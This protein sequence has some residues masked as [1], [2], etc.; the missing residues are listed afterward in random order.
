MNVTLSSSW[1][2]LSGYAY[3]LKLPALLGRIFVTNATQTQSKESISNLFDKPPE[4]LNAFDRCDSPAQLGSLFC[5]LVLEILKQNRIPVGS[6]FYFVEVPEQASA[7][8]VAYD[9][10]LPSYNSRASKVALEGVLKLLNQLSRDSTDLSLAIE[11]KAVLDKQLRDYAPQGVNLFNIF[12]AAQRLNIP[13]EIATGNMVRLGFG[14]HRR[15]LNSTITDRTPSLGVSLAR[16]K[17]LTAEVLR[18][19]GLPGSINQ[20]ANSAEQAVSLAKSIGFPVVVKPADL[21]QGVGV[22]ADLRTEDAVRAAFRLSSEHSKRVLIE[23][24]CEGFTHRLTVS[25][26]E[27]IRVVK[28]IA[29]GVIGDGT[30]T[31][32]ELISRLSTDQ[33]VQQKRTA[34]RHGKGQLVTIDEETLGLLAQMKRTLSDIPAKGEYIRLRRRDNINA[35]GRN[36]EVLLADVHPDNLALAIRAARLLG[37]DIAGIDFISPDIS[38]SWLEIPS[39]ICEVNA[40]PQLGG[41]SRPEVY[42]TLIKKIVGNCTVIPIE[43]ILCSK[44]PAARSY[45]RKQLEDARPLGT[46]ISEHAGLFTEGRRCSA[47]FK[48]DFEAA[49]ALANSPEV[50]QGAVIMD[51]QEIVQMGSPLDRWDKVS[52]FKQPDTNGSYP[53]YLKHAL[54]LLGISSH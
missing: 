36:E 39:I 14:A 3:G 13:V 46:Y 5:N 21:D 9:V 27:V 6:N 28:R 44:D 40:Q 50:N 18:A 33:T 32:E 19:A 7:Q 1:R 24:F 51:P 2:Q 10:A 15:L 17:F 35:G 37:L 54:N 47:S 49:K 34:L 20:P 52:V 43:L 4:F 53:L 45:L 29:G 26:G 48:T 41:T 23:K 25:H 22:S 8:A 42:D 12:Q 31:I 11:N 30:H 16:D 38:K